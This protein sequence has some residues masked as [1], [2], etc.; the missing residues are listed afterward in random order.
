MKNINNENGGEKKN[1]LSSGVH[2]GFFEIRV[3]GHLDESWS[4]WSGGLEMKLSE[5]GEMMLSGRIQ[6]QAALMGML[7]PLGGAKGF[8][9]SK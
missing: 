3:K 5:N 4:D 2:G 7:S 8:V 9:F 6:D 1:A